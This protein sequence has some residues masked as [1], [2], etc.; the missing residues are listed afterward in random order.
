[1]F[2]KKL[3]L[4]QETSFFMEHK[5]SC[6]NKIQKD[7]N[8]AKN[9]FQSLGKKKL[10]AHSTNKRNIIYNGQLIINCLNNGLE[11]IAWLAELF[12]ELL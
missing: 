6:K 11:T 7:V 5:N 10:C 3:R 9:I 1:M 12:G 2:I 8:Y 4:Q